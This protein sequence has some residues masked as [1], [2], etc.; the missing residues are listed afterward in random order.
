TA[1]PHRRPSHPGT[2]DRLRAGDGFT[3]SEVA[4]VLVVLGA[5]VLVIVVSVGGL[6]RQA[7]RADC[8]KERR[9]LTVATE[10]YHADRGT[11]PADVATLVRVGLL[12]RDE[13]THLRVLASAGDKV[14]FASDGTCPT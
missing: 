7:N 14:R 13:V 6:R 3:L 12:K 10:Q 1:L 11:Y 5:L 9:F 8:T 2:S 4:L